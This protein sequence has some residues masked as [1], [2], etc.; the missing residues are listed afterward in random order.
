MVESM[1]EN[2]G[3][4]LDRVKS[5][6]LEQDTL[7]VFLSDNPPI[8]RPAT[9][10]RAAPRRRESSAAADW[11]RRIARSRSDLF[12]LP[13][14]SSHQYDGPRWRGAS[15]RLQTGRGV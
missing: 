8:G 10:A 4:I 12:S 14:L 11:G 1:D 15:G 7:I 9:S 3:R 6:G 2:I 5:L 13:A